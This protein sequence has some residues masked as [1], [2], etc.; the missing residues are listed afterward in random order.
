[1]LGYRLGCPPQDA[2]GKWRL[3]AWDSLR[4]PQSSQTE[5]LNL[6]MLG[7]W[8][9]HSL[10]VGPARFGTSLKHTKKTS[11][12]SRL[13]FSQTNYPMEC[14]HGHGLKRWWWRWNVAEAGVAF[15]NPMMKTGW[16]MPCFQ[17]VPTKNPTNSSFR[18]EPYIAFP[19]HDCS[20]FCCS[21]TV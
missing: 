1:M 5:S 2:C 16:W 20:F 4:F 8:N 21:P 12:S 18:L 17:P 14:R 13:F 9:P 11:E 3:I 15:G 7:F 19:Y 6:T 10:R